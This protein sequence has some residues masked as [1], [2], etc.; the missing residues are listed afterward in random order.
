MTFEVKKT[1]PI[2]S[3]SCQ[4]V[5][6][7]TT[8]LQVDLEDLRKRCGSATEFE[9]LSSMVDMVTVLDAAWTDCHTTTTT[10]TSTT[11]V[12][13]PEPVVTTTTSTTTTTTTRFFDEIVDAQVQ[14]FVVDRS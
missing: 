2:C 7:L 10:T 13:T 5:T 6:Q 14:V 9:R 11:T 12:A 8:T 3:E 4:A 1:A